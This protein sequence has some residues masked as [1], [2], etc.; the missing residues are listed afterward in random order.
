M[1]NENIL[2]KTVSEQLGNGNVWVQRAW[3]RVGNEGG[4]A[5]RRS[6]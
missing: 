2:H 6:N 3:V 1:E 5:Q 4:S